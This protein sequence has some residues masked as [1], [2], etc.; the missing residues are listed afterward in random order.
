[1]KGKF[2]KILASVMAVSL[3]VFTFAGCGS[4]SG[5]SSD[6]ASS[7]EAG[8]ELNVMV[9]DGFYTDDLFKDFEKETGIHCN[10]SYITNTD[11]LLAKMLASKG[12]PDYDFIEVESAYVKPF[13][14]NDLLEKIDYSNIPNLENVDES[15]KEVPGDENQEYT[16]SEAYMGYTF[17]VYNTETCPLKEITSFQD[18]ADPALKDQIVSVVSTISLFGEALNSLGYE[19]DSTTE[20]EYEESAELWKKIRSN[21]KLFSGASCYQA[22]LDGEASVGFMFDYAQL[23]KEA[24]DPSIFKVAKISEGYERYSDFWCVPKGASNKKGAEM[25][26][27]YLISD[28]AIVAREEAY[29]SVCGQ[30]DGFAKCDE[31]IRNNPAFNLDQE[32]YDNTWMVPVTDTQ[33]DLMDKYLTE[34]MSADDVG[35]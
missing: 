18:L 5:G 17:I 10:V 14:D 8:D 27:N 33:I 19:P 26:M 7:D 30:P 3:S 2:K 4:S 1:M 24:P 15:F 32:I 20:S 25:L 29:P 13:V 34:F 16:C 6:G 12:S 35:S 21:V 22:M 11:E 9:W 28:D 31:S 23:E